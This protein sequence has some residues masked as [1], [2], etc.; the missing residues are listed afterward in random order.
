MSSLDLR[1]AAHDLKTAARWDR[2]L[3]AIPD[4]QLTLLIEIT[5]PTWASSSTRPPIDLAIALDRSGSMAGQPLSLAKHAALE[6][7]TRLEPRDRACL[8]VYDNEIDVVQ[9]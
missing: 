4:D 1:R 3:T 5:A 8:V 2:T 6:A 9:P 7:L